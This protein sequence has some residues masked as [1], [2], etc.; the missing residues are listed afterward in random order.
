M[1]DLVRPRANN[2]DKQ[3]MEGTTIFLR[4]RDS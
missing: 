4:P 1:V 3:Q 2:E